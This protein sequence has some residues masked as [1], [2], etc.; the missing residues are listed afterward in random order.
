MSNTISRSDLL[1]AVSEMNTDELKELTEVI[2][3][4]RD[5]LIRQ[6]ARS[7]SVGDRVRARD[8]RKTNE[9]A[10]VHEGTITKVN[11]KTANVTFKHPIHGHNAPWKVYLHHLELIED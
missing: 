4:R 3:V 2:Q 5:H 10:G 6:K 8:L 9:W 11:Q 1:E 7:F